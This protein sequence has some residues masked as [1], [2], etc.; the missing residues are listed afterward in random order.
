MT[1]TFTLFDG[2]YHLYTIVKS[3]T[4]LKLYIDNNVSAPI[5]DVLIQKDVE[6]SFSNRNITILNNII[7]P[8]ATTTA[9]ATTPT[10]TPATPDI[11]PT[12]TPT[13]TTTTPTPAPETATPH[14]ESEY[15]SYFGRFGV[16]D[17]AMGTEDVL[18]LY[19]AIQSDIIK[20]SNAYTLLKNDFEALQSK[21]EIKKKTNPFETSTAI[22][23]TCSD[24]VDWS[25]IDTILKDASVTCTRSIQNFCK[26][27]PTIANCAIFN[28]WSSSLLEEKEIPATG[29]VTATTPATPAVTPAAAVATPPAVTVPTP[30]TAT[31]TPAPTA[32]KSMY[33]DIIAAYDTLSSSVQIPTKSDDLK[34]IKA[35]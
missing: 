31:P 2:M 33:D 5:F 30:A 10:T 20:Q 13:P 4:N 11:A 1:P 16:F 3:E 18:T 35:E 15:V 32:P 14:T 27:D 34:V 9:P 17:K 21:I 12:E 8:Q 19:S 6:N 28:K 24:V 25:S 23:E 22:K 7:A 26:A 29:A